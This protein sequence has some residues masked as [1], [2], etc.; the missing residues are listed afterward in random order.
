MLGVAA[1]QRRADRAGRRSRAR[2]GAEAVGEV[3]RRKLQSQV[4]LKSSECDAEVHSKSGARAMPEPAA[5]LTIG[6]VAAAQR[7]RALGAALL[8]GRGPDR[9]RAQRRQPAALRA[10]RPAARG[11]DP[12]RARG[13]HPAGVDPRR[14]LAAARRPAALQARLGA[15][16]ARLARR[17]RGAHRAAR[18]RARRPRLLHRLRLPLAALVPALQPGRPRG[19]RQGRARAT[20]SA[21]SRGSRSRRPRRPTY[22][23]AMKPDRM[24]AFS[25]GV[26]AILITILVLELRPP[27]RRPSLRH[28]G[29]EGQAARLPAELR[30]GRDLLEQPPPPDVRSSTRSTAARCGRTCTCCSGSR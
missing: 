4:R 24:N 8:R 16:L 9:V 1:Q 28:P 3:M 10:R 25:D 30:D 5:M 20:C 15:A 21:T 13:G 11:G 12:G 17:R 26:I 27:R 14:P 29:R 18:A 19:R 22:S 6:Q 23:R 2:G 7:R